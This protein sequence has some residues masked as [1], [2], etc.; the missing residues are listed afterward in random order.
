[1][2]KTSALAAVLGLTLSSAASAT[3]IFS[4]DFESYGLGT[5]SSL[6]PT[7]TVN[8][9]TVDVIGAGNGYGWWGPGQYIDMNGSPNSPATITTTLTNLIVGRTYNLVFDYGFNRNSGS[10]ETLAFGVGT[11]TGLL[12][13]ADFAALIGTTFGN[14]FLSFVATSDSMSLFFTDDNTPGDAD[15][16][17]PVIDNVSVSLA[18]VPLPAGGLLLIGAL[19][20]LAALRRRKTA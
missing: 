11:T 13:P 6:A 7:W 18:A 19:G 15:A 8:P 4:D 3:V 10:Q 14:G 9:G 2:F 20:G 1:M 17:G 12:G 5:P 16:G